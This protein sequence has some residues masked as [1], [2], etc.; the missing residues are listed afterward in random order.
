M[1]ESIWT[2]KICDD[3]KDLNTLVIPIVGGVRQPTGL[4]D[5]YI[6]H[7]LWTGWLEFKGPLTKLQPKQAHYIE[8]FNKRKPGSAFVCREPIRI[9]DTHGNVVRYFDGTGC[10]LL[11][12]LDHIANDIRL[13]GKVIYG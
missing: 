2:R 12:S 5:R 4:P 13:Y 7:T 10:G 6:S 3:L 11:K 8:E 9:E 1:T